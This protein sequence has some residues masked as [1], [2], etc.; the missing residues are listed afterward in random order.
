M[1]LR[2]LVPLSLILTF[3][4][5][6]AA[7]AWVADENY[8]TI[9]Y[10]EVASAFGV[11]DAVPTITISSGGASGAFD[12]VIVDEVEDGI[13]LAI[14]NNTIE[15]HDG[16]WWAIQ[17]GSELVCSCGRTSG[18]DTAWTSTASAPQ[19]RRIWRFDP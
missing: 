19:P 12:G 6:I 14:G 18:A 5:L 11:E 7:A 3:F 15:Y 10:P 1:T 17:S 2:L 8:R 4:G 16:S 9:D 13:P